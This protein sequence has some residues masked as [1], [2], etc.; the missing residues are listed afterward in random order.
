[1][2]KVTDQK[3]ASSSSSARFELPDSIRKLV[4]DIQGM[5]PFKLVPDLPMVELDLTLRK[6]STVALLAAELDYDDQIEFERG[7]TFLHESFQAAVNA[8]DREHFLHQPMY[9]RE[10]DQ[11]CSIILKMCATYLYLLRD[12]RKADTFDPDVDTPDAS[13]HANLFD[14][15]DP[16]A[17]RVWMAIPGRWQLYKER[18]D[19]VEVLSQLPQSV[20]FKHD[21][22][23]ELGR[24]LDPGRTGIVTIFKYAAYMALMGPLE[25]VLQRTYNL[26]KS[27]FFCEYVSLA[28]ADVILQQKKVGTFLACF[29]DP[30]PG[31]IYLKY[32]HRVSTPPQCIRI[33]RLHGHEQEYLFS[34]QPPSSSSSSSSSWSPYT[35]KG[36]SF[37]T[38]FIHPFTLDICST[39]SF[40]GSGTYGETVRI[41]KGQP[42]GSYFIRTSS[43][44]VGAFVVCTVTDKGDV[45]QYKLQGHDDYLS[46]PDGNRHDS[47]KAF[48]SQS[49]ESFSQPAFL[50][51][52]EPLIDQVRVNSVY[53][54]DAG[55]NNA[56]L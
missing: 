16:S 7:L 48:L 41:L 20:P 42:K 10:I 49:K 51:R 6:C 22:K 17:Y 53:L 33:T 34:N 14:R 31:A 12:K 46:F 55:Y 13:T 26:V 5:N 50:S 32:I 45:H 37:L 52:F 47:F 27:P 19:V 8:P 39:H 25:G 21:I 4:E 3:G 44:T 29:A 43:S 1:M 56:V 24:V 38:N 2:K 9:H 36:A 35:D 15:D 40:H 23:E 28:D 18:T 54:Q 30:L 11:L